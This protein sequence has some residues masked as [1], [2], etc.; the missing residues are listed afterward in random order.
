[1]SYQ[2]FFPF[3][4]HIESPASHGPQTELSISYQ[5]I[6]DKGWHVFKAIRILNLYS[7]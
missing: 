7:D 3:S 5:E 6:N 4:N 2:V 1:M